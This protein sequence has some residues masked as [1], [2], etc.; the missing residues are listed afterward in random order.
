[1]YAWQRERYWIDAL[2]QTLSGEDTGHP[3]LGRRISLA[4]EGAVFESFIAPGTHGWLYDHVFGGLS[5]MP[6]TGW[7]EIF[8]AAGHHYFKQTHTEVA[9]L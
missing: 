1:L 2:P 5:I 8:W 6:G 7:A 4:G 3:L 9:S